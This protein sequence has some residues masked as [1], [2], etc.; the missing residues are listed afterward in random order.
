MRMLC[1][2]SASLMRTT[3]MSSAIASSIFRMFSAC[4]CSWLW[5]EKRDS[6]VTPST[7][8]ATSAPKLSSMSV[9]LYSVS[10]GTSWSSAA[11]TAIGSMPRSATIWAD[12]D[13]VGHVWLA[14]GPWL[15]LV[16]VDRE[17]ERPVDARQVGRRVVVGDRRLER[18]AQRLEIDLARSAGPDGR[19]PAGAAPGRGLGRLLGG[20]RGCGGCGRRSMACGRGGAFRA[21]GRG[22]GCGR[23]GLRSGRRHG[24]QG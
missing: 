3:R 6:F 2:R 15:A 1:S 14:G 22:R 8:W 13:R 5:V 7:R 20:C 9:R 4:C 11:S 18:G 19:R 12:G 17:V 23:R 16:R 21:R 24:P 10:S